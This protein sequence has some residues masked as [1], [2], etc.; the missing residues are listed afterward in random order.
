MEGIEWII[1]GHFCSPL[2]L[3]PVGRVFFLSAKTFFSICKAKS[4]DEWFLSD[5]SHVCALLLHQ[6]G[7][8]D[9]GKD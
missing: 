9:D 7:S 8:W 3:F 2:D 1:A 5:A 6:R 4:G